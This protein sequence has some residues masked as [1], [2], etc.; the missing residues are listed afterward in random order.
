[1]I[2]SLGFQ[3]NNY[4]IVFD[5]D[6]L[7]SNLEQNIITEVEKYC[8]KL[9]KA[10]QNRYNIWYDHKNKICF[11]QAQY[12]GTFVGKDHHFWTSKEDFKSSW[13]QK[14]KN[15]YK[16]KIGRSS[17]NILFN[18]ELCFEENEYLS[19]LNNK[20]VLIVCG[21]PSSNDVQWKNIK[22]D[23]VWTCNQFYKNNKFMNT[24][25]DLVVEH[26]SVVDINQD[27][28]FHEYLKKFNPIVSFEVEQGTGDKP[29]TSTKNFCN[30]FGY[31][32]NF[33][34]TR[35]RGQPGLGLRM[36]VFAICM[37][38]EDIYITGIDGRTR[39]ESDGNLLHA[40]DG[41]KNVPN[42][43]RKFGDDFQDRQ[44]VIFWDYLES[45]KFRYDFSIYNLGEGKSYNVM[46]KLFASSFPLPKK[47]KEAL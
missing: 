1:M 11:S 40:F 47:V 24:K 2:L 33:F 30:N 4:Q 3:T 17:K 32:T 28:L 37:G 29:Y 27:K 20:S 13:D 7:L 26:P 23:H 35:Y 42:W 5:G 43:Y 45:L 34:H 44:F 15:L 12:H 46:S 39:E 19:N 36:V 41:N 22:T 14:F 10:E 6:N 25:F 18:N 16:N 8:S 9:P 38:F 31:N 21:G